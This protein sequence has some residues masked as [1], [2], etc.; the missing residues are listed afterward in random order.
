MK[1]QRMILT[2]LRFNLQLLPRNM[3]L[4]FA[5]VCLNSLSYGIIAFLFRGDPWSREMSGIVTSND[6]FPIMFCS[7]L[8]MQFFIAGTGW[9]GMASVWLMPAGEFLLARPVPRCAAYLSRMFL[10]FIIILSAPLLKISMTT[11]DP[12]L[13][14]SLYHSKTQSTEAEDKL[15]LYRNQFPHSSIIRAPKTNHDM[16][17]VPFGAVLI[18]LWEFWL[19]ILLALAVQMATV[20]ILP[21]KVQ[22]GLIVAIS[23][24]PMLMVTFS[25]F[26]E[27]A[28][29][30][31]NLFFFFAHHW[32]L[33]ALLTL[34]A[35]VLVQRIALQRIEN[36]EVI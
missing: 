19:V 24:A 18:A 32:A 28:A 11:A 8:A 35:F 16:L 15:T 20:L 23:F 10:Y 6:A 7:M 25:P 29:L 30:I 9:T 34:G 31:E 12:D 33:I 3:W 17:V 2:M 21:S 27:Q 14:I 4:I 1:S 13:R 22:I 26:G 36:L 5:I